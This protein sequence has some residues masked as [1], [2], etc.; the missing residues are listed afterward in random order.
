MSNIRPNNDKKDNFILGII[1][2]T[3]NNSFERRIINS[4][5]NVR[6]DE[7]RDRDWT[8]IK[9]IE[10][11]RD[12]KGC[13][14]YIKDKKIKFNYFYDFKEE[15]VYI[16]KFVFKKNLKSTNFMF[17]ECSSYMHFDFSNFESKD[18]IN[19][20][21][22]FSNCNLLSSITLFSPTTSVNN[23]QYMFSDCNSLTN[24][25]LSSFDTS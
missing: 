1:N 25:D 10:N 22:M 7:P 2:L 11:E 8:K 9:A 17:Y 23:T 16:I 24:I 3:N 12:I 21:Y 13:E 6:R 19:M 5:E 14:I 4:Y 18:I 15:G 20:S